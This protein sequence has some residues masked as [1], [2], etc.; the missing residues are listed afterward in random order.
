MLLTT[1]HTTEG[2]PFMA[3]ALCVAALSIITFFVVHPVCNLFMFL[4]FSIQS[5]GYCKVINGV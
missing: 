5:L 1:G 3:D 2:T 4:N